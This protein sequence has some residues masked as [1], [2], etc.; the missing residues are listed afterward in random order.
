MTTMSK[1]DCYSCGTI[2]TNLT[3]TYRLDY[4][5]TNMIFN[6]KRRVHALENGHK[7]NFDMIKILAEQ[8]NY[9]KR[10]IKK[11]SI[12]ITNAINFRS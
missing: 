8:T 9:N 4:I 3:S 10:S 1:I 7:I 11:L 5:I 12:F 6:V 2:L